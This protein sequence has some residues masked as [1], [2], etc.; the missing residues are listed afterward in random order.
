MNPISSSFRL[1]FQIL[2]LYPVLV[3]QTSSLI[4]NNIVVLYKL[5]DELSLRICI[6]L[7]SSL[8]PFT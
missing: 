8:D 2:Y 6:D 1:D 5:T 7:S 3:V 4:D